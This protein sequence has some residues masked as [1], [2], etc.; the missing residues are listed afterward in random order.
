MWQPELS[1]KKLSLTYS[2]K[3]TIVELKER[4]KAKVLE[5]VG[6]YNKTEEE[7]GADCN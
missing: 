2:E 6:I 1:T 5:A 3:A 7:T 4:S